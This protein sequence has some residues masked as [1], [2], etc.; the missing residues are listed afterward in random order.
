MLYRAPS[1]PRPPLSVRYLHELGVLH[2]YIDRPLI[3]RK[4]SIFMYQAL[5]AWRRPYKALCNLHT[6]TS[7]PGAVYPAVWMLLQMSGLQIREGF[8]LNCESQL[9]R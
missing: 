9:F 2:D 6:I 8:L 7:F 1:D 3:Q 5:G 4:E